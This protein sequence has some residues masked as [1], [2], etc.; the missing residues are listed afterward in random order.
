MYVCYFISIGYKRSC[1]PEV[2]RVKPKI[3]SAFIGPRPKPSKPSD[4]NFNYNFFFEQMF[5]IVLYLQLKQLS[6][7]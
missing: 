7:C 1:N 5:D 6:V 4:G 2:S 3:K